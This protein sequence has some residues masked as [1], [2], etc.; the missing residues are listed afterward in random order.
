[1]KLI[2]PEE[3]HTS[4]IYIVERIFEG[5]DRRGFSMIKTTLTP[6]RGPRITRACTAVR[7]RWLLAEDF[8]SELDHANS[9]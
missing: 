3:E 6:E 7:V 5:V 4:D 1:M 8:D 9:W 2:P